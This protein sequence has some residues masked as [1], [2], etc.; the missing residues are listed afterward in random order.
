MSVPALSP[1]VPRAGNHWIYWP[2]AK[3]MTGWEKA[4]E[5]WML[6]S[7]CPPPDQKSPLNTAGEEVL[8]PILLG[9]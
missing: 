4:T 5:L 2:S 8:W 6:R 9:K 3:S 1:I 7:S